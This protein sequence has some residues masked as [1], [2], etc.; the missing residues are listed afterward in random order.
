MFVS[1]LGTECT[2]SV[3]IWQ[4]ER[5]SQVSAAVRNLAQSQKNSGSKVHYVLFDF[6]NPD[7]FA[8]AFA[9]INKLLLVRPPVIAEIHQK[10][11][12]RLFMPPF[13]L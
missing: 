4:D 12:D 7:T 6:T 5:M 1:S 13:L 9:G 10:I 11:R 3:C 8:D 2:V